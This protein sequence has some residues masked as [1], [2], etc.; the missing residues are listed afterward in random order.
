MK[1]KLRAAAIRALH[2]M[3]QTAL[4]VIGTAAMLEEVNWLAVISAALLAGV[5]SV[6]KSVI[7][8]MPEVPRLTEAGE[9]YN[10]GYDGEDGI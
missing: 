1:E 2:T 5:V 7:V 6:L 4:G 9:E 10:S 3:A 8:G